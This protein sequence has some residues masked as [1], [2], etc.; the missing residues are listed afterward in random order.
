MTSPVSKPNAKTGNGSLR[1]L[2]E[3]SADEVGL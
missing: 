3:A 2:I 1:D